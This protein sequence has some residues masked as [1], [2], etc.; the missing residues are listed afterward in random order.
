MVSISAE[1]GV[2]IHYNLAAMSDCHIDENRTLALSHDRE[3]MKS[4]TPNRSNDDHMVNI[5][6]ENGVDI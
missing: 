6:A 2:K 5:P 1:I 4:S 3:E